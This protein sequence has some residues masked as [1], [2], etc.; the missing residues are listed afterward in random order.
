MNPIQI[1]ILIGILVC[2]QIAFLL[3]K[4]EIKS[5]LNKIVKMQDPQQQTIV[6]QI[7]QVADNMN[8]WQ[9]HLDIERKYLSLMHTE[10]GRVWGIPECCI[11]QFCD[12]VVLGIQV[13][14]YRSLKHHKIIPPQ[15]GHVPCDECM[16]KI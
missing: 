5:W 13:A 11:K 2:I 6:N 9:Q 14:Q 4:D 1:L 16:K 15:I 8:K 12:E 3:K 7:T 10:V